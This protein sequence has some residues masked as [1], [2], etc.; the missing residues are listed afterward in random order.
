MVDSVEFPL[1]LLYIANKHPAYKV[2]IDVIRLL[3][4]E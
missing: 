1:A 2:I 4:L 3:S